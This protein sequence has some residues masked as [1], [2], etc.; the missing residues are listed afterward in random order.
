MTQVVTFQEINSV[1]GKKIAVITLNSPKSL[2]AL[3]VEMIS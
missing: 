3:S 1:N 2:N